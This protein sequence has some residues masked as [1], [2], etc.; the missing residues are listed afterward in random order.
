MENVQKLENENEQLRLENEFLKGK[1]I[2]L[3]KEVK[4]KE[5]REK[6]MKEKEIQRIKE[7]ESIQ[8]THQLKNDMKDKD[9]NSHRE[10]NKREQFIDFNQL[11]LQNKEYKTLN[12]QLTIACEDIKKENEII[13]EDFRK[14]FTLSTWSVDVS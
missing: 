5:I 2:N 11:I 7:I 10:N 12:D 6:E 13:I 1:I 8:N 3:E 4:E 14:D 9:K